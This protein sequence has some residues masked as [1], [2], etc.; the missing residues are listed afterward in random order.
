MVKQILP[1][2][3]VNSDGAAS[4]VTN[5]FSYP[6]GNKIIFSAFGLAWPLSEN[7]PNITRHYVW[8]LVT[9]SVSDFP[10]VPMTQTAD[11]TKL[12]VMGGEVNPKP[13]ASVIDLNTNQI[14]GRVTDKPPKLYDLIILRM[15]ITSDGKY[16]GYAL[17]APNP[18]Q[19]YY[20]IGIWDIEKDKLIWA[21]K[22]GI[23]DGDTTTF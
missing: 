8:D 2:G 10:Y 21:I 19:D 11:G 23:R 7:P 3:F 22:R 1:V 6:D 5:M 13:F 12:I 16:L 18:P 20:S 14:V 15:A 9:D 4:D 17:R